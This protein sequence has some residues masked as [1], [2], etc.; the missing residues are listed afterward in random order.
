M[1]LFVTIYFTIFLSMPYF[2]LQLNLIV[3]MRQTF[4]AFVNNIQFLK[5]AVLQKMPFSA[6]MK[7]VSDSATKHI[8]YRLIFCKSL[9]RSDHLH[10]KNSHYFSW[11]NSIIVDILKSSPKPFLK[12]YC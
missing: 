9:A 5:N 2:T 10:K 8:K 7:I 11:L 6:V 1:A 3:E 12:S 4:F